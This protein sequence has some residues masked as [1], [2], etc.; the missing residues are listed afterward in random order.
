MRKDI[1]IANFVYI[2]LTVINIVAV[3]FL[4]NK[5]TI[6]RT[7]AGEYRHDYSDI[8]MG[9]TILET[10]LTVFAI[11]LAVLAFF[12]YNNLKEGAIAA[13]EDTVE[14]YL[15]DVLPSILED[16]IAEKIAENSAQHTTISVLSLIHI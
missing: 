10:I 7:I 16:L 11:L 5:I 6:V 13:A 1:S 3:Y 9:I 12:S 8:T 15:E 14:D 4:Y 2:L